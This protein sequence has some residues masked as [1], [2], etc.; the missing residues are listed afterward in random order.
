MSTK[1]FD[2]LLIASACCGVS[3]TEH[4]T[5]SELSKIGGHILGFP[6][7]THEL[8]KSGYAG[9]IEAAIRRQFMD[10][11]S[12]DEARR[13]WRSAAAR[14]VARYGE[15]VEVEA[16]NETRH[17]GPVESLARITGRPEDIIVIE[18]SE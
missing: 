15:T 6:V 11:P 13:D 16:G 12:A 4:L 10:M 14:S 9:R 7:W 18:A 17:E 3:L 8:G 5:V 1:T 2:T